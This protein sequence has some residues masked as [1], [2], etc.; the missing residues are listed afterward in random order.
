MWAKCYFKSTFKLKLVKP[1]T[2]KDKSKEIIMS[3]G[4]LSQNMQQSFQEM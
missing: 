1:I 4:L 2:S 3:N